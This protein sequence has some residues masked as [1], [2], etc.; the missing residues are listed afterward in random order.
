[1]RLALFDL[2]DT[3]V[4]RHGAYL[5]WSAEF[6]EDHRLPGESKAWLRAAPAIWPGPKD[7][8]LAVARKRFGLNATVDQLWEQYR[9]RMP[10]LVNVRPGVLDGLDRLRHNGWTIGIV[11]NGAADNQLGKIRH[12][13]LIDRIDGH[14]LSG[15]VGL[16]KPD[17]RIFDLAARRAGVSTCVGAWMIGDD[18]GLD[19]VGGHAA[20]MQTYWISHDREWDH[21]RP[22]PDRRAPDT[23]DAIAGLLAPMAGL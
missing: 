22:E 8:M 3:L 10:Q 14:C 11:S 12:T 7:R 5:R 16:R 13:G 18:P 17:P 1:M 9:R 6:A 4:D 15:E 19:I 20:G 2:D 23:S 21:R